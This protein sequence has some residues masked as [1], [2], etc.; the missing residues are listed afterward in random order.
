[1]VST[2]HRL[3]RNAWLKISASATHGDVWLCDETIV[4]AIR[5]RYLDIIKTINLNHKNVNSALRGLAGAFDSSNI[6]DFYHTIF[7]T[8]CPYADK[9]CK[10]APRDVHYYYHHLLNKPTQP[11]RP[12]DVQDIILTALW[13][14]KDRERISAA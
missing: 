11:S 3:I 9:D 13:A 5:A 4:R 14:I 2:A 7:R 10:K 12:F 8:K 6:I 1:M